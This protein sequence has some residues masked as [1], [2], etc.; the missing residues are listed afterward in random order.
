MHFAGWTAEG[1]ELTEEQKKA[2]T[3]TFVMPANNVTLTFSYEVTPI[4][5]D[6]SLLQ[7]TY[8]YAIT[9]DTTGVTESA[10]ENLEKLSDISDEENKSEEPNSKPENKTNSSKTV[11]QNTFLWIEMMLALTAGYLVLYHRMRIEA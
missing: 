5:T 10:A 4:N 6:K 2:E 1:V 3:I 7:K 11:E 8:D 9:L